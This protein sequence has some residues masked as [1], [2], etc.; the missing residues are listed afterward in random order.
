MSNRWQDDDLGLSPKSRDRIGLRW[1]AIAAIATIVLWQVPIGNYLLYPFSILATWFH[2]MGHGV[3]AMLLGGTFR[4]LQIFPSGSGLAVHSGVQ[5]FGPVGR[6]L[7]A[8]GGP[9]GP[10]MAGA[11]LI[12]ASRSRRMA[13]AGLLVLAGLLLISALIWVRS[14]FG[15]VAIPLIGLAVLWVGTSTTGWLQAFAIQFLGLQACISTYHQLDYLFMNRAVIGG[16][17]IVSDSAQIAQNLLL[18]YWF[19]GGLMAIASA[20]L[21]VWSLRLA[22]RHD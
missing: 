5:F 1:L 22:Y 7:V 20:L 6:A 14:L 12:L 3:T 15:L 17:L 10:P 19:L 13:K 18:P 21:L 9:M 4:Q 2:E 8:M 16:Q 11:A